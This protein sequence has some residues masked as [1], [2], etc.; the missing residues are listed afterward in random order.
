LKEF[1]RFPN[2][3][4]EVPT[5]LTAGVMAVLAWAAVFTQSTWL[6]ALLAASFVL[7]LA[8]GSRGEPVAWLM[9]R[10]VTPRLPFRGSIV[11]GPPKRFAQLIGAILT[12]AAFGAGISGA[13]LLA[14]ALV[15]VVAV[16]ATLES[17]VGFCA[18]CVVFGYLMRTGIIPE[19]VCEEC[20]N[21]SLRWQR[22][23]QRE[24][25]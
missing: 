13:S 16:F 22:Q 18:G 23:A 19:T 12:V 4:N 11:P 17:V 6:L 20:N 10:V 3:V 15:A 9:A 24:S 2:P 14:A 8:F 25:A 5:R 21:I 1:F 7:R